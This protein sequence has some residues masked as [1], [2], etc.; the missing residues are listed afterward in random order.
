V[1]STSV[2]TDIDWDA[3]AAPSSVE[4]IDDNDAHPDTGLMHELT[5]WA[6]EG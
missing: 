4:T 6:T 5:A 3:F 2:K 1:T